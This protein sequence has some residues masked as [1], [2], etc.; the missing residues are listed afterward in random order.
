MMRIDL[1]DTRIGGFN[2]ELLRALSGQATGGADIGECVA[3]MQEVRQ[4]DTES[5]T[6][7]WNSLADR[8]ADSAERFLRAEQTVSARGALFRASTYYQTADFYVWPE[9]SRFARLS[10]RSQEL[11]QQAA[12]LC[13]PPIEVLAIPYGDYKLPGYFLSGGPGRRPTLVTVGGFD[14]TGEELIHWIGFAARLR[15][16]RESRGRLC[17]KPR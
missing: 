8:T 12:R 15:G 4:N 3:A 16:A 10:R 11:G 14:S 6:V 1:T 2:F 13:K 9:D 5:W 7:A 17:S